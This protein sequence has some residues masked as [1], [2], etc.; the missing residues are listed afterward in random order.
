MITMLVNTWFAEQKVSGAAMAAQENG[1]DG[2]VPF[3]F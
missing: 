2:G 3:C 1:G